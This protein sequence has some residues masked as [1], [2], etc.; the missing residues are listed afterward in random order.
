MQVLTVLSAA[1]LAG[2]VLAACGSTPGTAAA[3]GG[4]CSNTSQVNSL[5]VERHN[6]LPQNHVHFTFAAKVTVNVPGKAR[7]V[8]SAACALPPMPSG[9]FS[10]GNDA[11]ITYRLIFTAHGKKLSAA[12]ISIGGCEDAH[13]LDQTRWAI[14]SPGFWHT[15]G[16]AM[17]LKR[18][19]R[20]TF[21]G[22]MV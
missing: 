5:T 15:L 6:A 8:A 13:G 3:A 18:P 19:Y 14:R 17:G 7:S 10:C 20:S 16:V 2:S 11:G 9:A 4:V 12:T 22:S 21:G 1:A